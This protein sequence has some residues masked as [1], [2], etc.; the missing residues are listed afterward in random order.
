MQMWRGWEGGQ[1]SGAERKER[2]FGYVNYRVGRVVAPCGVLVPCSPRR[3]L[4]Y[5]KQTRHIHLQAADQ[6]EAGLLQSSCSA[7]ALCATHQHRVTP[8][9]SARPDR[10]RP[11]PVHSTRGRAAHHAAQKERAAPAAARGPQP[12]WGV[13]DHHHPLGLPGTGERGAGHGHGPLPVAG[14]PE[15][16]HVHAHTHAREFATSELPPAGGVHL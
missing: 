3:A 15:G 4:L 14:V 6:A 12:V 13:R 16:M 8:V 5:S 2:V 1:R 11:L 10:P 7:T 9:H